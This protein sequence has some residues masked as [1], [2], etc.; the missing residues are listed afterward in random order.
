MI[1]E[2]DVKPIGAAS[3]RQQMVIDCIRNNTAQIV[4]IGGAAG[5]VSAETEFLTTSG[6]V[7][8][9]EYEEGMSI[10]QYTPDTDTLHFS[11]EVKYVKLPCQELTRIAGKG[12]EM[13]LSDEHNVLY[14]PG[15]EFKPHT[16]PFEEVKR[17]HLKSKTKGWTGKIK[18]TFKTCGEGVPLSEGE[19]RLQVAVMADGRV[20]K[21]G[22]DNYTQMRFSKKRKYDRLIELCQKYN[23]RYD[24]RGWEPCERYN[25]GKMYQV[26]VWPALSDKKFDAKYY[27]CTQDQLEIIADEVV[28]WDGSTK[29]YKNSTPSKQFFSKYKSNA[30]F[31]QYAFA[32]CGMNTSMVFQK[33]EKGFEGSCGYWTVNGN[34]SGQGFRSFANK[35]GKTALETIQTSDGFKYCFTTT[36]GFFLARLNNKVFLTG[37][38]GKSHLLQI[39]P[40]EF[41]D[42]PKARCIMFRR[43]TDQLKGQGGLYELATDI[44]SNLPPELRPRM[45]ESKL[46]AYFP[47]GAV[48]QWKHMERE[49]DRMKHQGLT[50]SPLIQ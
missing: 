12:M 23:L 20:V 40:L 22:K 18:T 36:T 30:D 47:T 27:N 17:R 7:K 48:V 41:A 21:G 33:S 46:R 37:N 29:Q 28:H 49:S 9:S 35:D 39:L 11:P 31:I 13:E 10:A 32:A 6:W 50:C 24:D 8:F 45:V 5:C 2:E 34:C 15:I 19:L 16:L 43:E 25:S 14:W 44:Y 26:I 3:P 1:E 4:I 42:D 38:S